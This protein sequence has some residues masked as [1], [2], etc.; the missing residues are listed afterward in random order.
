MTE[1]LI[2]KKHVA[3][4]DEKKKKQIFLLLLDSVAVQYDYQYR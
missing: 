2:F 3:S 1:S 4:K